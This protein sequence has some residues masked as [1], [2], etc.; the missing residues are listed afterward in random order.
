MPPPGVQSAHQDRQPDPHLL[1]GP[2]EAGGSRA[3]P[4]SR[5]TLFQD[6]FQ[7]EAG[8]GE[9]LQRGEGGRGGP[10]RQGERRMPERPF[11]LPVE[12]PSPGPGPGVFRVLLPNQLQPEGSPKLYQGGFGLQAE[13]F[14]RGGPITAK[15]LEQNRVKILQQGV[16][17]GKSAGGHPFFLAIFV[18]A[19][20]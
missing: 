4:A 6:L 11:P 20:A 16:Q 12:D 1:T 2:S 15:I 10:V 7:Q 18:P 8:L 13:S 17:V 14:Q 5:G 19:T 9:K 3:E